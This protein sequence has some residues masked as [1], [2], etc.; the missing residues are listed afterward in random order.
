MGTRVGGRSQARSGSETHKI[1]SSISSNRR[2]LQT[3]TTNFQR[4][5]AVIH[6]IPEGRVAT[7][8]QV[9]VLAGLPGHA[10]QVGYALHGSN[11]PELPWQRVVNAKGEVS[12]RSEPGR[13]GLQRA[14][15]EAEGV[16]FN[17][18][19]RINLK[20]YRWDP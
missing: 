10:R 16:S 9:A 14:M 2:K 7:Y 5:E 13:E 12:P 19:G 18:K 8:G 20:V 4:I 11:D 17:S 3:V 15:L 1:Y 6:D